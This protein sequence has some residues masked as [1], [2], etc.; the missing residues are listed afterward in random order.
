M[1]LPKN[2]EYLGRKVGLSK[3]LQSPEGYSDPG[4]NYLK[5]SNFTLIENS[6]EEI[7]LATQDMEYNL[8]NKI[9]DIRMDPRL[10]QIRETYNAPAKGLIAPS[11]IDANKKW[12]LE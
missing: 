10:T 2:W 7:L 9:L 6:S 8:N 12:F 3:L 4:I 5:K 11:Y 1:H